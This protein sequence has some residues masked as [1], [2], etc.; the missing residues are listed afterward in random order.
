MVNRCRKTEEVKSYHLELLVLKAQVRQGGR[1]GGM[2][3]VTPGNKA[4]ESPKGLFEFLI[5]GCWLQAAARLGGRSSEHKYDAMRLVM[6]ALQDIVDG[7]A[8]APASAAPGLIDEEQYRGLVRE[9][10]VGFDS[11]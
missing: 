5:S 9:L 8:P 1:V 2:A 4:I 3:V 10:Q 7:E 6:D 11:T